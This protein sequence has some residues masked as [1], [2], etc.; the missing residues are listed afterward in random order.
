MRFKDKV[1]LVTGASR[2]IGQATSL[3]FANEG[4]TVAINF[5]E[6]AEG[7]K[8]T[9]S[10][11][12]N[13]RHL[14]VCADVRNRLTLESR[15]QEILASHGQIDILVNNA[16]VCRDKTLGRMDDGQW[17]DVI[18]VNLTGV[19]NVTRAVLP[20]MLQRKTGVIVNVA[21]VIA[22]SGN[23]GQCNYAAAK[24]GIIGL[25]R[26]L[27]QEVGHK[28]IRVNAVAPG[29]TDTHMLD[30]IPA[31]F[32]VEIQ[33]QTPLGRFGRPEEIANAI[34]FLASDEASFITGEVLNVNGGWY[35]C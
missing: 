23:I 27:A 35:M 13:P 7:A 21:S 29:F 32:K 24:A 8:V 19:A 9:F 34:L 20:H 26:S 4:A 2:G 22:H 31:D 18:N 1:V 28:G 16:G 12:N 17:D 5:Y 30:P 25:T 3:A 15:V 10:T 6:D 33:H 14:I 11:L